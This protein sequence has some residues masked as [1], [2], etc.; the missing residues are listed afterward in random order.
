MIIGS[1][2]F[3]RAC[4]SFH[5]PLVKSSRIGNAFNNTFINSFSAF[6]FALNCIKRCQLLL[7]NSGG[8]IYAPCR[9][10]VNYKIERRGVCN[11]SI[12]AG[13]NGRYPLTCFKFVRN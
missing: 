2:L 12:F 5:Q 13:Y 4:N 10:I 9:L 6:L 1:Q 3:F 7:N 11:R 8:F